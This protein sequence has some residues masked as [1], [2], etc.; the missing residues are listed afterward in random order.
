MAEASASICLLLSKAL[1]GNPEWAASGREIEKQ[2]TSASI[3]YAFLNYNHVIN[4]S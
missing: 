4:K 1:L 2:V 3:A